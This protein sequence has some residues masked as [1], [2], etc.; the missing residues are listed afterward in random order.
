MNTISLIEWSQ[1]YSIIERAEKGFIDYLENWKKDDRSEFFDT[2]N[3]KSNLKLLKTELHS[4]QLTHLRG[5]SDFVYCNLRI[6]Y[7]GK[8][9]G[10]YRMVFNLEGEFDDDFIHFEKDLENIINEGTIKV[11]VIN[12]AIKQGYDIEAISKLVD[13]D[14]NLIRPLFI[15]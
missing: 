7:L 14:E 11:K 3:G 2:F 13:L 15:G 6:L 4:I 5:Y 12:R 8:H 1:T 9:I 10:E